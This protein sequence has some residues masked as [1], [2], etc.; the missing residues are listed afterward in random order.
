[1]QLGRQLRS[2]R[3]SKN[4]TPREK[5]AAL[6]ATYRIVVTIKKSISYSSLAR[7]AIQGVLCRP[8][9]RTIHRRWGGGYSYTTKRGDRASRR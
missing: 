8:L 7:F 3:K 2:L 6:L 5:K 9:V 1:M 4:V